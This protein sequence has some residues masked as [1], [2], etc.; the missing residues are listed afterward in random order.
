MFQPYLEKSFA[1]KMLAAYLEAALWTS[2]GNMDITAEHC[3]SDIA[4]E[5]LKEINAECLDFIEKSKVITDLTAYDPSQIGHDF[6]LTRNHHGAGFWDR[7]YASKE[8]LDALTKLSHDFGE[9]TL[10]LGDDQK[11]YT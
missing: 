8:T 3:F 4:D 7:D 6:W 1:G 10:Y 5:T 9:S 11:I 2:E